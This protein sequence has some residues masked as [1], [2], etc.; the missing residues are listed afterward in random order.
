MSRNA[1]TSVM[2]KI[3]LDRGV[4]EVELFPLN[5]MNREVLYQ[6]ALLKGSRG[7]QVISH[8]Q[9][10]SR[11]WDTEIVTKGLRYFV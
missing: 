5:V 6:P 1:E 8:L 3:V 2:A 4:Q 10:L 9:E 7:K 11:Q